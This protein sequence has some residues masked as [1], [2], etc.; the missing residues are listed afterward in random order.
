MIVVNGQEESEG[1][2]AVRSERFFCVRLYCDGDGDEA[3]LS[4]RS[5]HCQ[6]YWVALIGNCYPYALPRSEG[7]QS[8]VIG[9]CYQ[10]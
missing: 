6:P 8:G 4:Q 3:G 7:L 5:R 9:F 10:Q 1:A 2:A